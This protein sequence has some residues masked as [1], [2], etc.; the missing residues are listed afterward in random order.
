MAAYEIQQA[1]KQRLAIHPL[2]KHDPRYKRIYQELIHTAGGTPSWKI[3]GIWILRNNQKSAGGSV[4]RRGDFESYRKR[5]G[6]RSLW[7]FHGT[8]PGNLLSILTSVLKPSLSGA[9]GAGIYF[10][11]NSAVAS[12]YAFK[13]GNRGYILSCRV[14]LGKNYAKNTVSHSGNYDTIAS[15]GSTTSRDKHDSWVFVTRA[16]QQVYIRFITLISV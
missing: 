10:T 13:S 9:Y 14:A 6:G 3:E 11:P 8:P 5:L 16:S 1:Y 15:G 2:R 7:L 4:N 12:G